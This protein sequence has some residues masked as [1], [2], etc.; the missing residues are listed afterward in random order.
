MGGGVPEVP[1][2]GY[3][4]VPYPT[5]RVPGFCVRGSCAKLLDPRTPVSA[6][7]VR[8]DG[9]VTSRSQCVPGGGPAAA[10]A[11]GAQK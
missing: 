4:G 1:L 3:R 10:Q 6:P 9:E 7:S 8:E 5:G 11:R 2:P